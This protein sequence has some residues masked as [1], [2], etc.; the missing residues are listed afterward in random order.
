MAL[1]LAE[2]AV[3]WGKQAVAKKCECFIQEAEGALAA[4]LLETY[5]HPG[6]GGRVQ[7]ESPWGSDI[8]AEAGGINRSLPDRVWRENCVG[9]R[10]SSIY[11]FL[12]VNGIVELRKLKEFGAAAT[13]QREELQQYNT[14]SGEK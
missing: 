13:V 6:V 1:T 3:L 8:A 14:R 7:R 10:G 11:K 4:R 9:D 12:E 2:L 5:T